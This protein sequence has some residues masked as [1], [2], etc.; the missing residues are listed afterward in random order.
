[1]EDHFSLPV[2]THMHTQWLHHLC[3]HP[4]DG[5]MDQL[6]RPASYPTP[7]TQYTLKEMTVVWHL[8]GGLDFPPAEGEG[9]GRGG[10]RR[11]EGREKKREKKRK[12]ALRC[13]RDR[14]DTT[15]WG[16]TWKSGGG[17]ARDHSVLVE[18]EL[19]KVR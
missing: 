12:T 13:W 11:E 3:S 4:Q 19:D 8:Y 7:L 16:N 15:L 1:M 9:E 5:Q 17:V 14:K 18:V 6:R 2:N 10:K